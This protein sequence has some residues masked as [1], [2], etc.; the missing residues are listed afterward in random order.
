MTT[1]NRTLTNKLEDLFLSILRNVIL[2]VLAVSIIASIGFFISALN[3]STAKAKQ[4]TYEKFDSTLLVNELKQTL[5][6]QPSEKQEEKK[7]TEKKPQSPQGNLIEDELTKQSN[8]V[9]QYYKKYDFNINPSWIAQNFKPR[10]RKQVNTLS[11][12]Y[13]ENDAA[14][15]Q[16]AAGQTKLFEQVL[17]NAELNELLDKKFKAQTTSNED[18]RYEIVHGFA[19]ATIDFYPDFHEKQIKQKEEFDRS[20]NIDVAARTAGALFKFYLAG[21]IFAAFLLISLILVLVKIE[22]NLRLV[23]TENQAVSL[24]G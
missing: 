16:Y 21:G 17:L 11:V 14:K 10:L 4:Y 7:E 5:Q 2:I 3:D 12:V 18:E 1:E 20:E 19:N 6:A 9:I 15:Q 8:A 23:K 24:N 13:G 22:R